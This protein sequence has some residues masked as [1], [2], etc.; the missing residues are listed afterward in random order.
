MSF[1]RNLEVKVDEEGCILF[2]LIISEFLL[3]FFLLDLMGAGLIDSF[4]GLLLTF[5]VYFLVLMDMVSAWL[6]VLMMLDLLLLPSPPLLMLSLREDIWANCYYYFSE[7][8]YI[9]SSLFLLLV[10]FR[11]R[12]VEIDRFSTRFFLSYTSV[13][14][15]FFKFKGWF[16]GVGDLLLWGS[17]WKACYSMVLVHV[18]CYFCYWFSLSFDQS[19]SLDN[20]SLFYQE[21]L[22]F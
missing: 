3:D 15:L 21:S 9:R 4:V 1:L 8:Y 10:A 6:D 5:F 20:E 16:L 2:Y 12:Y 22:N 11:W 13:F 19:I 18:V 7:D 14:V 17:I